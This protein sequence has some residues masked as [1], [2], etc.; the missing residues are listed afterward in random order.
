VRPA[1]STAEGIAASTPEPKPNKATTA[2]KQPPERANSRERRIGKNLIG[3][4][5]IS[6]T[7]YHARRAPTV[8]QSA[9]FL[10]QYAVSE[11]P[12]ATRRE[13]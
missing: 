10:A 11:S 13:E 5:S 12:S 7:A 9:R 3:S 6:P 1:A 4:T 2:K 8:E